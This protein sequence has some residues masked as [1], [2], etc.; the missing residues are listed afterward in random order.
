MKARKIRRTAAWHKKLSMDDL[1]HL[2]VM[3]HDGKVPT[4]AR[5]KGW[6]AQQ[7][8]DRGLFLSE[9]C[10]KCKFIAQKLG[11]EV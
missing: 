10:W 2:A 1:R 4:L 8:K 7:K 5:F 9:P 6:A 11:L 3:S